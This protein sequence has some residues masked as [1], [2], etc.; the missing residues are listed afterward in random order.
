VVWGVETDT[1]DLTGTT[2][3]KNGS[4]PQVL[5]ILKIIPNFIGSIEQIPPIYSNIKING[6][7]AHQ[8]ARQGLDVTI[9]P[10]IVEIFDLQLLESVENQSTFVV[11][12]GSGT[13]IRSLAMDMASSLGTWGHL[14]YLRR[15]A[16]E[17]NGQIINPQV[18]LEDFLNHDGPWE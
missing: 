5:D 3:N 7:R 17:F 1:G 4:V 6:I 14:I 13:Y 15:Q 16:V 8:L 12:V 2:T 18:G 11:W 10:R 9:Q